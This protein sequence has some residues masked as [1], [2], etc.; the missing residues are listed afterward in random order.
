ME[1]K[2]TWLAPALIAA[3]LVLPPLARL[4]V[5][6]ANAAPPANAVEADPADTCDQACTAMASCG[7]DAAA[8]LGLVPPKDPSL[9]PPLD[10]PAARAACLGPCVA[11]AQDRP[12]FAEVVAGCSECVKT[13]DCRDVRACLATCFPDPALL[14]GR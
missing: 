13:Y 10:V 12:L 5:G 9:A 4:V 11:A 1:N 14:A 7:H 8:N 6:P 3:V 2:R